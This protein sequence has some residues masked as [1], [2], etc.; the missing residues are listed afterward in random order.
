MKKKVISMSTKIES[1][2]KSVIGLSNQNISLTGEL[3]STKDKIN[4]INGKLV[5]IIMH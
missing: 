5:V 1:L 4:V 2:E 3:Q